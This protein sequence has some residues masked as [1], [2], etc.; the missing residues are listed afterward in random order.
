MQVDRQARETRM[1][2]ESEQHSV[3]MIA[4]EIFGPTLP[5]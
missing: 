4:S 3:F 1:S 5:G 2:Q